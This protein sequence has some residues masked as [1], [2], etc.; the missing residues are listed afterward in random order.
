LT[1]GPIWNEG[2]PKRGNRKSTRFKLLAIAILQEFRMQQTFQWSIRKVPFGA[3][4]LEERERERER[5][6]GKFPR[7]WT[8][9]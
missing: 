1:Y 5:E 8:S 3:Q 4:E 9:C 2:F 6:R 7:G